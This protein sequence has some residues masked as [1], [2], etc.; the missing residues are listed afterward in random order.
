MSAR[1]KI[2]HWPKCEFHVFLSHC[3]EDRDRFVIPLQ[4]ELQRYQ[5]SSWIDRHHYP[6]GTGAYEALREGLL[7]CRH[8]IYLITP[9]TLKRARG[10]VA[11]EKA[12]GDLIQS[13][14][15]Y[16]DSEFSHVELP[17]Y[18]VCMDDK[19]LPRSIWQ[20]VR[21]KGKFYTGASVATQKA[22]AWA[23]GQIANF[24]RQEQLRGESIVNSIK[25]DP[26]LRAV[27]SEENLMQRIAASD[28]PQIETKEMPQ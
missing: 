26:V 4:Q 8:I 2:L 10:W 9:E 7:K 21:E 25:Q 20:T 27:F 15:R 24:V 16:Q 23:A 5:I 11:V 3:A 13:R 22:V 18:F 1:W 14:F 17:L 19:L 28:L 6:L 12:Y